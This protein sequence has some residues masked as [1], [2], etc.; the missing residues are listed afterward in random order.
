MRNPKNSKILLVDDDQHLLESM[1]AWLTDQGFQVS[2]ASNGK[3]ARQRL[4]ET[5]FD[6]ALFDVRIGH[7]DG[8]ELLAQCKKHHPNVVVVLMTGYATEDTGI[9]AI[10]AGAFD[11]I[12]KP[13]IDDEILICF[14]RALSQQKVIEE[15]E[16]LKTQLDKRFGRHS[17]IGNDHRMQKT[18]DMVDN[19]ADTKATVMITGES[20]TGKSLIAR[21]I[22]QRSN[23]RKAPFV[24]VACGALPDNLLESE[25]FGHVAGS[26]T[27]ATGNK[28]GKFKQSDGGTIFL[29]EIGTASPSLQIKLLRVL[30]EL[31]FEQ[32]GGTETFRVNTR[33]ILATNEDLAKAVAEDRF[34]Q[35]LYYRVNV[36]NIE[37][38]SLHQR[39]SDIPTLA[40][41]FLEKV[42][43]EEGKEIT[44]FD[45]TS[46]QAM[47]QYKWPG[48]VRELQNIVERAVLLGSGPQLGIQ[49]LPSHISAC[50][51]ETL[52]ISP[53]AQRQTLKAALE[54]PER[55]IIL[56]SLRENNW[57][58]NET[59]EQLGVNRTTLY[60]KMKKLGL[61]NPRAVATE[62]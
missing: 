57:N 45:Q 46:L 50:Q 34:R 54:G 42:C 14:D 31:E 51:T 2:L 38:P 4:N 10:R 15:N 37:L 17:I 39:T 52:T 47:Q 60:K 61:E 20:G 41:H 26:F 32:V 29:D 53:L 30:Q 22:H 23:R 25:L 6:L 3:T 9:E 62:W 18:F 5:T 33:I 56:R 49:D 44:G 55:Q 21:A 27:G 24:E 1:G 12:T 13:L 43:E 7:D 35:D 36:I 19:I 40:N 59:A 48:N 16:Q 58:R 11:L 8:F 28:V